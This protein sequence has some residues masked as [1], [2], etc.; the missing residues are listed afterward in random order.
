MDRFLREARIVSTL[1]HPHICT[2]HDIG[3]HEGQP[4]MVMELLE[5]ESLKQRLARGPLPLDDLL[6]LGVQSPTRST[7]RTRPASSTA[8]SSRRISSL[9]GVVRPRCSTSVSPSSPPAI[10]GER[11]DLAHTLAVSER[12]TAGSAVGTVAYMSPEQA[13]GLE[14]DPRSDLF[15]FGEVLYEMATGKAAFPGP[16]VGGDLRGHSDEA[17]NAAVAAERQCAAGSRSHHR[18][19][20]REGSR[21]ALPDGGGDASRS[22]ALEA[23]DGFG[24]D[25]CWCKR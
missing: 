3:E 10:S 14:I 9:P 12:T 23:G 19:G 25:I 8:T 2:L 17:A 20:A 11:P 15:S 5:G 22:E 13:R 7:P 6:D 1:S 16:D 24:T 18:Q 4:F 21:D